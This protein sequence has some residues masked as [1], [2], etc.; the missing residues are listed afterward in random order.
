MHVCLTS[1][2]YQP[3]SLTHALTMCFLY[4]LYRGIILKR[5]LDAIGFSYS[6]VFVFVC[7][8]LFFFG[9]LAFFLLLLI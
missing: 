6:F 3:R 1:C 8:F 5:L 4:I 7:F 9:L 2:C